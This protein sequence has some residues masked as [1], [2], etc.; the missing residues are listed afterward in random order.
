MR[1][2]ARSAGGCHA[3]GVTNRGSGVATLSSSLSGTELCILMQPRHERTVKVPVGCRKA[4]SKQRETDLLDTVDVRI[5]GEPSRTL[6]CSV[7]HRRKLLWRQGEHT[8]EC[9]AEPC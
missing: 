6:S 1:R 7:A 4:P 2:A 5:Q 3:F 9:A 8:P